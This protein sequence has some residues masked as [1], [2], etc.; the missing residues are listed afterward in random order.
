MSIQTVAIVIT[1]DSQNQI[2]TVPETVHV[3]NNSAFRK[4]SSLVP[5]TE[6]LS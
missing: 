4:E 1:D 3:G 6:R 5:F 2:I